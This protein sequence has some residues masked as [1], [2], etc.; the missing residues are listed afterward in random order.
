MASL[1]YAPGAVEHFV[2]Y[3]GVG[4]Y[5]GTATTAPEVEGRPY[6]LNVINDLGGRSAPMQKVGDRQ[7][8]IVTT[9]LNRFDWAVYKAIV[10]A[11]SSG[12]LGGDSNFTQGV[13][14]L[15]N[16]DFELALV[17]QQAVAGNTPT[18]F[19]VGR[20]Y[21]S[22]QVIGYRESTVGT[23]VEEVTLVME[24]NELF[25]ATTRQFALY[26]EN[27]ATVLQ[28]LPAVS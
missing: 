9:T 26:S 28:G 2:V 21:F 8:H 14:T 10:F 7:Q 19:P 6:Y 22:A 27:S 18:G 23:R 15:N 25:D 17:F 5:L 11:S 3:G 1:F 13:L 16:L 24:C 12:Q 20:R 4:Y